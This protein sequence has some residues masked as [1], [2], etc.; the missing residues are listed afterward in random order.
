MH[1]VLKKMLITLLGKGRIVV[2]KNNIKNAK[3]AKNK[4][5]KNFSEEL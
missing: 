4:K 3:I 1:N 2:S 5:L